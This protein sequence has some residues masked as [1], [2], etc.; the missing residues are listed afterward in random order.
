MAERI[1]QHGGRVMSHPGVQWGHRFGWP[2]RAFAPTLEDKVRNYYR[3]WLS[4]YR[5]L[6]HPRM[7][8]MTAHWETKMPKEK[9][10]TLIKDVLH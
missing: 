4:V 3:G 5:R 2:D 9:L 6:D 7:Q 1:R 10:Q 8:E